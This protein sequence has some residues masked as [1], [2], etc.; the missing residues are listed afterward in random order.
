MISLI[1]RWIEP[2]VR[3][4][5]RAEPW[6]QSLALLAARLYLL[7]VFFKSGLTKLQDWDSTLFLFAEEYHVPVLPPEL[8]AWMGTGGELIFPV[9]LAVGL[10]SRPA[11]LGVFFLNA[12]AAYS[13]PDISAAGLKDHVLWAVLSFALVLFGPGRLALDAWLMRRW[14]PSLRRR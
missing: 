3:L 4:A 2:A 7:D 13:Y 12:V 6:A 5:Q 9:L 8:A 14:W 10:F 11:A 1:E